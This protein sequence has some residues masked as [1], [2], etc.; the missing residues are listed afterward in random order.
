MSSPVTPASHIRLQMAAISAEGIK[1]LARK[2]NWERKDVKRPE[3][4]AE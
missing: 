1:P 3:G 4:G 2:P